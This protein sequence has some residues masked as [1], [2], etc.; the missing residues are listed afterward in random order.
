M[1]V[2]AKCTGTLV[3]S[4]TQ[5]HAL[6]LILTLNLTLNPITNFIWC[7]PVAPVSLYVLQ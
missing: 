2:T 7:D 5:D 1:L 4:V 6:T 3:N